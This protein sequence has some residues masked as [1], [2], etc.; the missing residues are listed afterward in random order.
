MARLL[1]VIV[2]FLGLNYQHGNTVV[3]DI[4]DDAVIGCSCPHPWNTQLCTS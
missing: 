2:V 3:I 1:L 4:V